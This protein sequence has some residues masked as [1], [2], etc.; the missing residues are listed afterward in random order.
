MKVRAIKYPHTRIVPTVL[1]N[2]LP[3]WGPYSKSR[4]HGPY[5]DTRV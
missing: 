5:S 3:V 4:G 1:A 2:A